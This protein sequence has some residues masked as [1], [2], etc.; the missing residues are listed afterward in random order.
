MLESAGSISH[1]MAIEKANS[2]YFKYQEL[3]KDE[4]STV[5]KDFLETVKAMQKK[6][7]KKKK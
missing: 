5:E 3:S 2:E 1:E 6:L 4:L 7:E